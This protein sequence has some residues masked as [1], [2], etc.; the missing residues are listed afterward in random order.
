MIAEQT[1]TLN[2]YFAER[3][4]VVSE[5]VVVFGMVVVPETADSV[6]PEKEK[7]VAGKNEYSDYFG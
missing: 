3:L 6:G 5:R 4:A 7:S 2:Y 1:E